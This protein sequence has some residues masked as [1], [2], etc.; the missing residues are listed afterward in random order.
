MNGL[1]AIFNFP[2]LV[3]QTLPSQLSPDTQ[4]QLGGKLCTKDEEQHILKGMYPLP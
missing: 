3:C 2:H 4:S 1:D